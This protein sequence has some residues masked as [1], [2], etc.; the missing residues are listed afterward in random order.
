M[1][2]LQHVT[3]PYPP[4]RVEEL[5][6]FYCGLLGMVEKTPP[7]LLGSSYLWLEAGEGERELHFMPAESELDPAG[8]RHFCL[9]LEDA[10]A[11]EAVRS[12]LGQAGC[13]IIEAGAI[14]NRPR[15]FV[16]DPFGNLV[17][18]LTLLGDYR[19]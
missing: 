17:E 11:L 8:R 14:H 3:T 7:G 6:A 9:E 5:R 1:P 19:S 10:A 13:E 16:R 15:F 18:L 12:R 4:G 2:R